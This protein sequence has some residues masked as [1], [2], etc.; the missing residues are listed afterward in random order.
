MYNQQIDVEA[1]PAILETANS[2]SLARHRESKCSRSSVTLRGADEHHPF[3]CPL[4]SSLLGPL[5]L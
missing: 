4:F 2:K 3:L 5:I 1:R